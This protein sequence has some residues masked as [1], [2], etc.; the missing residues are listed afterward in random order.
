MADTPAD[1][2]TDGQHADAP[3]AA[4]TSLRSELTRLPMFVVRFDDGLYIALP[5]LPSP[6]L[7]FDFVDQLFSASLRFVDLDYACLQKLLFECDQAQIS[8]L[9]QALQKAGQP[10]RLRLAS[11]IA[12]FPADRQQ[13]YRDARINDAGD[14]EYLFEPVLAE[15]EAEQ[16]AHGASIPGAAAAVDD[17]QAQNAAQHVI[18]NVDELIAAMWR[19]EVRFGIDVAVVREALASDQSQT[20]IIA[21]QRASL[22]GQDAG[23]E[24][25]VKSL[26]RDNTPKLLPD[27]RVD[28]FQFENRFP[29]VEV[30]ARLLK[31]IPA[32]PG[33]PGRDIA[34]HELA[35]EP[36]RDIDIALLAGSGT[37][38]ERTA[39]GEFV[40]AGM[41]GFLQ[42]DS[43]TKALSLSEK[44]INRDGV[45]LRTTGN[46]TLS[47]DEYEEHGEVE[48][49][50]QVE[51]K[52]MTFMA[53][54]FGNIVSH[55][56]HVV[57][58]KNLTT[59]SVKNPD[60]SIVIEGNASRTTLEALGGEITVHYAEG[61]LIIGK[62]VTIGHAVGCEIL[63]D[64]LTIETSEGSAL[65]GHRLT[66]GSTAAWREMETAISLP[67]PDL[68]AFASKLD[69][70]K[71]K[72]D[73][74][75]QILAMKTQEIG[76]LTSH[77]D[78]RNYAV[79]SAK[80]RAREITMTLEQD[81]NW[82]KL[83][84]RVA[85]VL[86]QLKALNAELHNARIAG[87]Y[88]A[89]KIQD[90][91]H[92]RQA[93]SVDISCKVSAI[94]GETIIRTLRIQPD[95]PT[96]QSLPQRELRTRLRESGADSTIL[97]SG[98]DG[99]FEWIFSG[100]GEGGA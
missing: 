75:A 43:A 1:A 70:C 59:G 23:V 29:Q 72:Q 47:G 57:F 55:G 77:Q 3:A 44:I 87:E 33:K 12:E 62:K 26:H 92:K 48:E 36:P 22:P 5:A 50:T 61:C 6:A 39:E 11:D 54:V 96:L 42:I 14:A 21:R 27:G 73:E 25:L 94:T 19:R 95:A 17:R 100:N 64:A 81:T 4:Q 58:K 60:G 8:K 38:V 76:E 40:V 16:A 84:D 30:N 78:V 80:L 88:V 24:E 63:A 79:L 86:R 82:Q 99:D 13:Y 15:N 68:S 53:N 66:I 56:G 69:E 65:A 10:P 7:L 71:K 49:H 83:Q 2:S 85:P 34:G 90:I 37:K 32:Q 91:T 20:A 97:Y 35:C 46:L 98:S 52:H 89:Q 18:F 28:L 31:K 45:S 41:S 51:G 93:M 74:C 9:A 67:V